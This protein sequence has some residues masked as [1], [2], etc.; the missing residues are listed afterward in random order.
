[1]TYLVIRSLKNHSNSNFINALRYIAYQKGYIKN[2][3]IEYRK[4]YYKVLKKEFESTA[5]Q[6]DIDPR[7]ISI[8]QY[9]SLRKHRGGKFP[10]N[11]KVYLAAIYKVMLNCFREDTL[12]KQRV[13]KWLGQNDPNIEYSMYMAGKIRNSI[14]L[15]IENQNRALLPQGIIDLFRAFDNTLTELDT[16]ILHRQPKL[17]NEK[18]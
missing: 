11:T 1:M 2:G 5:R 6:Y 9:K 16:K 12:N 4:L 15:L 7:T 14:P 8:R 17:Y 13:T 3:A 18:W 10:Q